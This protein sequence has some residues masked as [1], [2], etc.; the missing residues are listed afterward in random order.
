MMEILAKVE[1]QITEE[2]KHVHEQLGTIII[3][4]NR[5]S[6]NPSFADTP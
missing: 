2:S 6:A 1:D 4:Q 3:N 5:L